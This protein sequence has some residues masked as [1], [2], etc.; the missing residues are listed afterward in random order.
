[1]TSPTRARVQQVYRWCD[2]YHYDR[3][4]VTFVFERGDQDQG[5]LRDRLFQDFRIDI[6]FEDKK[7]RALQA[8]DLAAWE[9]RNA[10]KQRSDGALMK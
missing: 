9:F 6:R 2:Q 7:L 10:L 1:M 3:R 5:M 8:A 4:L